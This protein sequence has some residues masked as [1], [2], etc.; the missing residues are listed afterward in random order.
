VQGIDIGVFPAAEDISSLGGDASKCLPVGHFA[1]F[2]EAVAPYPAVA[3]I[4]VDPDMA[5]GREA[6]ENFRHA[7][8]PR[9]E[10]RSQSRNS[11]P[12]SG[13]AGQV[14]EDDELGKG[15]VGPLERP[16]DPRHQPLLRGVEPN[17][18]LV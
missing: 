3:G 6:A 8:L 12:L 1:G 14:I 11:P 18:D 9:L 17:Q 2:R 10:R 7:G 13:Q 4:G 5:L 16:I 15:Q